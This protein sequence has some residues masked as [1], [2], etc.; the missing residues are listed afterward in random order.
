MIDP[1]RLRVLQAVAAHGSVTA[2]ADA[3]HLTPPAVSQQL[4]ALERE[5]GAS[6][7]DRSGRQVRLTAAGRLLAAHGERIAAQLRQAERDLA[8]LTG[9]AAGPV[10]IAAFQSVMAPLIGPA[11][12]N[13]AAASPAIQPV[14][15]ERYGPAAVADLR[16]GDL[17]IVLTEYDAASLRPAEPG[18]ALRHLA[19]DPY[20]LV[21]PPD[22]QVAP[23]S[24]RDLAG[25]PWVAGPPG[26]SCDQ[27]L[28]RLAAEADIAVPAGDVC[29]EFPSVLALVAAGRGAA[30]IPR[31]ALGQ[32]PVTIC[33]LPPL[34]GRHIAAW[35]QA[36]PAQPTPATV[37]VLGALARTGQALR[38]APLPLTVTPGAEHPAAPTR[39]L[40]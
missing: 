23:R 19:F 29:V 25:R 1:R 39:P 5:T 15:A 26:T 18:L 16:L 6:L 4:L 24:L 27:A 10:R 20:L 28:R 37:T 2:A 3:L 30:I 14:V 34:G 21:I 36:G 13:L 40:L 38:Q 12:R 11:L 8:E 32:A 17:D 33:P 9:Q 35:H 31:L 7:V 22:W